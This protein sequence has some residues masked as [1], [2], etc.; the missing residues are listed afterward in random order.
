MKRSTRPCSS[1]RSAMRL[2]IRHCGNWLRGS[3]AGSAARVVSGLSRSAEIPFALFRLPLIPLPAGPPGFKLMILTNHVVTVLFD[4]R[5]GDVEPHGG[6]LLAWVVAERVTIIGIGHP[7]KGRRDAFASS[8][9]YVEVARAAW[10]MASRQAVCMGMVHRVIVKQGG[11]KPPALSS[12]GSIQLVPD[13]ID[14]VSQ[15]PQFPPQP[16]ASIN[17]QNCRQNCQLR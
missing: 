8:Q 16:P 7:P 10:S 11:Q 6:A 5:A 3:D 13:A 12:P 2:T 1:P 14:L 4:D 15:P 17:R 9:A